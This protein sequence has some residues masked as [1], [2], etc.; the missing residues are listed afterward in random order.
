[1]VAQWLRVLANKPDDLEIHM[2]GR[3]NTKLSSDLHTHVCARTH[4]HRHARAPTHSHTQR[5][6]EINFSEFFSE[7]YFLSDS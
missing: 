7:S 4:A 2:V 3:E 1:M 6:G 5:N